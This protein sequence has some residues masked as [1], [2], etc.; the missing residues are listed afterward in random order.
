MRASEQVGKY[1]K[2]DRVDTPNKTCIWLIRSISSDDDLGLI[3]WYGPWRCYVF[4]PA[5]D[6]EF[7]SSCMIALAQFC[8][9]H[10]DTRN[11]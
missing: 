11:D 3:H 1:M 2:A 6:T 7:N 8:D 9:K 4:Q 10:K 5:P